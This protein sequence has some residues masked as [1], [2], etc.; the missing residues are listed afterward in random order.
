VILK[1]GELTDEEWAKI[2]QHPLEGGKMLMEHTRTIG[3][4]IDQLAVDYIRF[5]HRK[6]DGG[7]YGREGVGN[8]IPLGARIISVADAYATIVEVKGR[9]YTLSRGHDEAMREIIK[10]S[11]T[12]FDHV[13]V[14]ALCKAVDWEKS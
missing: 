12:Q 8:G 7:G 13:V 10:N 1:A 11:G 14:D 6:W 5:H 9:E 4:P 3:A 2:K